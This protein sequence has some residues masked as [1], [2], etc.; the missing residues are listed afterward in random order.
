[1]AIPWYIPPWLRG[2]PYCASVAPYRV[3]ST[4][5][6]VQ[7]TREQ[8]TRVLEYRV[9]AKEDS[10]ETH[11]EGDFTSDDFTMVYSRGCTMVYSRGCTMVYSRGRLLEGCSL[12]YGL[13]G[14]LVQKFK[15]SYLL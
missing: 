14:G 4:E 5:Y 12:H 2:L 3:Q 7:G 8:S 9:H 13:T 11:I 6:R 1:M 10:R 15:G